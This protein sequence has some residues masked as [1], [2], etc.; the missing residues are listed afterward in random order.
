MFFIN[1]V[2]SN[3]TVDYAAEELKKYLRM[4]MPEGGD[5]QIAYAPDADKGFR[6]G[7]MQDF[8]LDVSDAED[9][10][11]DD[12]LYMDCDENGGI[13]AGD[14]YR[15]VLLAV[16][17]YLR[18]NGCR[19]LM[20]GPDGEFIP[21][22]D[23]VP[24]KYRY[25]PSMRY[26]G[27]CNEGAESQQCMLETIE[28][29]PKIGMNTYMLEFKIPIAYYDWYYKH[30]GNEKH[31]AP[32]PVTEATVLQWK[33][34]CEAEIAKRGL[35]FH[36]IGH[37]MITDA[38]NL[39]CSNI[40]GTIDWSN[41]PAE[42]MEMMAMIDGKRQ[43]YRNS[44]GAT[45]ICL[46]NEKARKIIA[47]YVADYAQN[48]TNITY[49]HVWL[50]DWYNNSCECDVCRTKRPSDWYMML[51]NDIDEELT[52]RNLDTR[53]VFI[54]YYDSLWA[55]V[56]EKLK[57]HKRFALLLA[58]ITREY[59]YTLAEGGI[60]GKPFVL[61][62]TE[63]PTT[64]NEFFAYLKDW[65]QWWNGAVCVY[66]YH[67]WRHQIDPAVLGHAARIW[68]DVRTYQQYGAHGIIQ[69]GSQRSFFPGGF[70]F[71][72]YART[73]YDTS[74]S[75]EEIAEEYFSCAYGEDWQKVY[76]YLKKCGEILPYELMENG[77][78]VNAKVSSYYNPSLQSAMQKGDAIADEGEALVQ[79]NFNMPYRLQTVSYRL[80]GEQVK[81]FRNL[82]KAFSHK[83]VGEDEEA[84]NTFMEIYD[85]FGRR[86]A[87]LE[88]YLDFYLYMGRLKQIISV[89]SNMQEIQ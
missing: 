68:E 23:I 8:G 15:S 77:A 64:L 4:M 9:P 32:E 70:A 52:A 29:T 16:Y 83:V 62:K 74:L 11:L 63:G 28:F 65:Q 6:L 49:L 27:Q 79:K 82:A 37:G 36:D 31:R 75:F 19:W 5:V 30:L 17:E 86:E 84:L 38:F 69:D 18:Q 73:L 47:N 7:L 60:E 45:C 10:E 35:Q 61:N 81:L 2:T 33:R 89:K 50:A 25:K 57:N 43:I 58:P 78:S 59:T 26:R 39:D 66:E 12:I 85:E 20:P 42:T 44:P 53:I 21:M 67:F 40:W 48:H 56:E 80:L 22:Q 1:K 72:T 34:A 88:R 14:N 3:T 13:I 76:E 51:M 54:A 24:V 87:E 41:I 71:Y 46:S 55:P